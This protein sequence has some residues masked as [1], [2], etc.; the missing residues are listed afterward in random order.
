M[1][2]CGSCAGCLYLPDMTYAYIRVSTDCQTV[3]NQR[4]EIE[5]YCTRQGLTIDA[6]VAETVSGTV[7]FRK[8]ELGQLI[9]EA[10]PGDLIVCSELSRLGRNMMMV[11]TL[12]GR[13]IEAGVV[14]VTIKDN[15]RFGN[16]I[17]SKTIAFAFSLAAEIER[18]LLSRRTAEALRLRK[19]N[20]VV[21]GRPRGAKTGVERLKLAPYR[22]RI[23]AMLAS[24]M[25]KK[26]IALRLGVDR[27]TLARYIAR[28][29]IA[30]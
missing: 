9:D 30:I 19:A 4:F 21:L 25:T 12:L 23:E 22:D 27:N 20:G 17:A 6:W 10:Q 29:G 2:F 3:D 14:I 26:E 7:D 13:L 1:Y 11:M 8:R 24:G 15:F 16:D 18:T 28:A 5:A